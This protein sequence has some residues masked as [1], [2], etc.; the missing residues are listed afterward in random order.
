MKTNK[1]KI[2]FIDWHK[3]LSNSIF[4][5][6]LTEPGH[7]LNGY[8]PKI[9]TV[10]FNKEFDL[11]NPWMLG[12]LNSKIVCKFISEKTGIDSQ[13]L[14]DELEISCRQMS[15]I[16]KEVESLLN[17]LKQKGIPLVIATDNMD[18]FT[19]YTYPEINKNNLFSG[20]LNSYET[21]CFKYD[22]INDGLPFFD[23]YLRDKRLTYRD[24]VLVD[25]SIDKR[26]NFQRLGFE[27]L[28]IGKNKPLT[29]VLIEYVNN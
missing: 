10:L 13:I 22:C 28:I 12:K 4:W 26:R 16:S 21:G 23:G 14:H 24:V 5:Q 8:L 6:Q 15:L 17:K 11:I 27:V 7:M 9:E 1:P 29:E 2:I 3:T 20:C 25:D 19:K 18:T